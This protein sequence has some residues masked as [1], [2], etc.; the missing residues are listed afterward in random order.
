MI[1]LV[2]GSV[3][4]CRF[5]AWEEILFGRKSGTGHQSTIHSLSNAVF[6]FFILLLI[7]GTP[8]HLIFFFHFCIGQDQVIMTVIFSA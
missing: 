8:L 4:I 7:C 2:F 3:D 5:L 6:V 1:Q